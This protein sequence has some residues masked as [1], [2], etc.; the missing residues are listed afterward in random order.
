MLEVTSDYIKAIENDL[1]VFEANFDLNGKRYTKTKIAS[2]TYD[3]SISNSNDFTIGGGYIN[4]L[5]IEIKEIIE[6]LQEMMPATMSV[7]IAGK[8]VPLGKFFV[9]EVKLDRN[10]KKT[11]IKLQDEFI[12]L[13]GAYDSQLTY[14][15]YTRDILAEI[16]R[17]TGITT[18]T[19]IQLV[20]DQVAKKLE[21]TSYREALVYLA[22]LSGSFV[23]FN[24]NG[25]LDFIKLK[26]TSRHITKDMYKPGG[27]ERDE[28]PYRLKGIEC[29]S[30]DKVVYKSG[31]STGNIMKIKNP[32]V[33]QEILDRVF[34]EY[35]DFNFYPYTL[36]WRGD[37]AME[38]GDWVTVHWDENIY[39]D[40]PMLSYKL[41]FDGGLSAHSSGNAA[42]VAQ[43]TYKYKGAMQRQIEYLDELITKQGSMYLDTSNPTKPKNGD[44]WFKPNG[45]YVEMWERVEGS[46]VKKADSANVGE[47]VN[48]ITTDE[49]LAKKVSAAIGNYITLNAKNITAGDLDLARLRI[50][51]GL[52]EI[53]SIRDGKVVMNIDKLTINSKDVATKEDLKKIELT[54]GPQGERGQQGV[55]G[56]QGL[57]GPKGDP[58]RDGIAGKNGVGLRSTVI[59]YAPS[60]SGTNAPNSGWTSS[61]PV[62]PAGQ[63]LWTKTTWNYTDD[64]SEAGYSVARIGRDGN[65]GRDGVA[66]KDGVG[67]R[68]TAISYASSITGDIPPSGQVLVNSNQVIRPNMSVLDNMYYT[69]LVFNVISGAKYRIYAKSSNGVFSNNHNNRGGNNVVIWGVSLETG[70][71]HFIISDSNTG[72]TG[73]EFTWTGITGRAKIRVN[74]Y[75]PDNSTQ[76]EYIH[77]ESVDDTVW[78]LTIPSVPA[79][80]YLWTRTTWSYTDNTSETGFSVAKMGETGQ[81]G[82]RGDPG[83]KGDRGE[84]GEKGDRGERGLQGL[85]GLQGAKGDQGIPGTRGADGRTTYTHIAYADTISGSGFSQTDADKSYIGVYVDFNS[86]DSVNPA[87]YRW[88][89]W[90]GS[91][92]L[93]G[94]D[95]PQGIP[96]KPG[97]DG[98]TPYLHRA[99]ANSADG[100]DGFS[101]TDSTNKRYLGT[102]TDFTE[103]DSQ[104]PAQ[105]KWTAL[106]ENVEIG[107]RNLFL[108]SLF[109]R[110]L[111]ERYSTY[112]LDDSQEQTQGQLTLSIDT[113]IKFRGTNTLKIVS[114]YN[115]KATNQKATFR[116]GGD[117]RLGTA[118]EMKNKAVRFSFWAKST[119]NNTNFQARA[120]YRNTVRGVSLTTD[121]KFY[122]IELTKKENSNASNELILHVFTAATVWIAFPKVEVGTVS[123]DFSEAPEDVQ[124][125]IDSKAD[126]KLTNDQLN[127]LA[128]KA[129]LHDVELKAKATMD[130]FSDLEKAYNALVKS[131]AESQKKSESDLIEAGRRIEFLSIEFGGLKEMKKFIDT[132]MSASNEGLIIG[133]NNASSSIKVSHDRISMFSAGKEVMYIS[134]GVIHIDNGIFTAS[135]QIGRFRTEQYYLDKDV[136]VIRYVGG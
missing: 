117:I 59:T 30:A 120:G 57:Q 4:S 50:M 69:N 100:R 118:D 2:A 88:T 75:N 133:K 15:A 83:P 12:R 131:N 18:A 72:T 63:Y 46:W 44:I 26:T 19:N 105:Y 28:I 56:I 43:G 111:R 84:K 1:R 41:S 136:N 31:L 27:L 54:P 66:G 103:A 68:D 70:N 35:R 21:K 110:S 89:R 33:T 94:K 123:T 55:P 7:A 42:G 47:I 132:Y 29:E 97:A 73:T 5:E 36:S 109:K 51:N 102:Y 114:T 125:D 85:Q 91:D 52:Q 127:A 34:N 96:G 45:G 11:K 116:T 53:V 119:V 25:K 98:R 74:T 134:Q 113:N 112:F 3:S 81:K 23:R 76:V 126:H 8:T 130:Q 14:P 95:G 99:W 64:T 20:N 24:R 22:Q 108:N 82:D 32:W 6:G 38:A 13:S 78:G 67:I 9:T 49:L 122:D 87:D 90:R 128:E 115:G 101:T 86:T 39:F 61:V 124:A 58:G 79:G 17:L 16:V 10:D 48:T 40:I 65:T 93:N 60:T 80:Q 77:L 135:V 106:F 104:N 92:G 107:G 71:R 121:W 129:Q 62:I 37:M